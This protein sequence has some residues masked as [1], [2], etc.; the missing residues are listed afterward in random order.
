MRENQSIFFPSELFPDIDLKPDKICMNCLGKKNLQ[1]INVGRP[2][3]TSAL[4][5][6]GQH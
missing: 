6:S 4:K 2:F 3:L 1:Y 5:I